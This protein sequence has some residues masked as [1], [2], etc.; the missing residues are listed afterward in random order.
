MQTTRFQ[1]RKLHKCTLVLLLWKKNLAMLITM[2][3]GLKNSKFFHVLWIILLGG[4]WASRFLWLNMII[5]YV[6]E[7]SVLI[8]TEPLNSVHLWF[9]AISFSLGP[10]GYPH[11]D[12]A[13]WILLILCIL[14]PK[15]YVVFSVSVSLSLTLSLCLSIHTHTQHTQD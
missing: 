12:V 8:T 4:G 14:W 9:M 5:F 10:C 11:F 2:E 1:L 15:P 6:V 13:L 3:E 7:F